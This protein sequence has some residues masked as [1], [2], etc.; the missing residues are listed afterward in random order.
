MNILETTLEHRKLREK[1]V[2]HF[3]EQGLNEDQMLAHIYAKVD[4]RLWPYAR[5]NI[6][7]HLEKLKEDKLI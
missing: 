3:H 5:K 2:L 4:E 6:Q 7:K 1:Q